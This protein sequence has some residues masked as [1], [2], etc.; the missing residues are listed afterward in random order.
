MATRACLYSVRV[1]VITVSLS[2]LLP[3]TFRGSAAH[4]QNNEPG[5]KGGVPSAKEMSMTGCLKKGTGP[6]AYML[7][8]L[9]KGPKSVGIVSST[10][11]LAPHIGHKVEITGTAVSPADAEAMKDVPKSP[12]YMKVT[13]IKM[14]SPTC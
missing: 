5:G 9:E 11:N 7:T 3:S 1:M 4:P 8:D 12:H 13:A 10:P 14:L 2:A 6:D